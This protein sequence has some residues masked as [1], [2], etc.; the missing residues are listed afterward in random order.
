MSKKK[1]MSRGGGST[2]K[3]TADDM[4]FKGRKMDMKSIMKDI[5][6]LSNIFHLLHSILIIA[7]VC[8]SYKSAFK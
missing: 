5:E 3:E 6:F 4:D 8:G 2:T 7:C 1:Q